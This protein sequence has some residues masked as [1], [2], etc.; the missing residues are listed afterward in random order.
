MV[1]SGR[2]DLQHHSSG[3]VN[4]PGPRS[5]PRRPPHSAPGSRRADLALCLANSAPRGG[6]LT[7]GKKQRGTRKER[8]KGKEEQDFRLLQLS[9]PSPLA[10][11]LALSFSPSFLPASTPHPTPALLPSRPRPRRGAPSALPRSRR[12][13][14]HLGAGRERPRLRAPPRRRSARGPPGGCSGRARRAAYFLRSQEEARLQPQAPAGGA[15][16]GPVHGFAVSRVPSR[17]LGWRWGSLPPT[18]PTLAAA[19]K[20]KA[21]LYHIWVALQ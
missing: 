21:S 9:F 14:P 19:R 12:R 7:S 16:A 18:L 6:W 1:S 17:S 4:R 8:G 5:C 10:R 3:A 20:Q 2:R 15:L 11:F 13:R